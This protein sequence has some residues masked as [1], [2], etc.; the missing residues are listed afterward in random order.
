M[1]GLASGSTY[2]WQV[3]SICDST[4]I[5]SSAFSG[6]N[7]FTLGSCNASL[8]ISQTNVGCFGG[9]DGALDLSVS[10]GSGSFSYLWSDGSTTEDLDSLSAG[11]YSVTVTDNNTCQYTA[12][13]IITEPASAFSVSIIASGNPTICLGESVTLSMNS[14]SPANSIYQW[15]DLNG[16]I[17]GANSS[18]YT[19]SVSGTYSLTVTNPAGCI[20]VSNGIAITVLSTAVPSS[21]FTS[22]I[23]LDKAT[24]NWGSV[25]NAHKYH[26]RMRVQGTSSWSI[27]INNIPSSFTSKQ[28]VNL[29]SATA[30]EWSIRSACSSDTSSS[31]AWSSIQSFSTLAPCIVPVNTLTS[32][33]TLSGASLG[34]DAVAGSYGYSVRYKGVSQP[35]SAWTTVVVTSNAYVLSGLASGSTYHWQVKSICDST[36]INSSAFSGYNTFTLGSCN[37]SLNISQTNVGCFGGNDGALDL[38]VSGGSGSFSYLW[39][40]GSTTEDL[41]SLSAGTYSVTVTDNNTCQYTATYIIT[42]PAS[43]FSVSIIASGNPTICLGE[44]VTLSMNSWSPANSIY[45]WSDLNGAISGAN[46]ST[47]TTSVSGTYS[48]TVT[49]PAGCIAVSNGIAITVLSTAVPS[50]LFTSNIQ[51]DKATMNWGSVVNAHKYHI[52]MRVQGTSSWSIFINNIPSSFTSKQKVNLQSATA[53]EWSIRSACSSDTSSSS[54][55]SSIQSFS[56]LA[57]CIVPVNTLTSSITLSGASLGWDAVAGSYGYSVRYKGVS[58]PWSAWTTVVVTSNAYVLSGLASG[59]TYHWQVK[60]ICDSTGINSS[61]FSGYNTFTLGSCN[62]SLN[63]SQTNVGCFGGNDGALDLSVSGGSGSFSYLWSDGSTTEDLDSLSAG[64]YSVTVTDNNTCQYTATYIITEP[65]SAFSV[66]IIASGNP[67]ICLG[68][69]VTL[70]MN[71]WSPANSIYQ[72]SDLNGAISGANSS[73]YTTSVSGTYSLTVTNPAGCIAVSNGIAITVLSTAVPSS[74]FTSN[75]QLDKATMN[76]G[77]VVNA[78]KYHIRMRVQGTSSWSIFIN[79]IPSSFTSKQKVNLQSATAYEWS[80]RSACSSDTSSSSAWSSIQSFSTLAPCIVPVNTLTSSITLSGASLGWDAVAGSY[81]YSVRYKGVSQP[82]SAWTTVVVTSNAYVL[83]GLASG[84]TYHWQVKSICDSTGINSSAFSG[85]NTFTLG[86]CNASLNISQTNVG[87]FGGNDGA[88]DLSVSG[89]SGSF[90]YLWSDGSTTEDLDS[91]SAGTYSVTV[92]DNN[93]CQY[94]ATYIIT[95]PASAF[96]VSIIASGNPTICLGESV[97]L[98]MNSWSPANSIYQWSDLNGAIS[99][100]NSSTYTTSVSGTYSL[101]VTNP[102]GCIAVSNGIAI[103]VLSTA[104]PSSLF[105]SNIQLDKATMNWGSVVNAHKYHIRMRVQGTSSWSIFINNIPSSFTS[106]QKVNLQSAT[107]Y[108]WSIRS[109]CSSDTSSSSAWSSIQ[110]FATLTTCTAPLNM[111]TTAIGLTDATL[112]WDVSPGALGYIVRYKLVNQGWGT[113]TYDTI[114]TNLLVLSSLLPGTAYHW[115]VKSACDSNGS[116]NSGFSSFDVFN[117][118]NG[119][120]PPTNMIVDSITTS[121]AALSWDPNPVAFSYRLMYLVVGAPWN[122]RIDTTITPGLNDLTLS[123]LISNENYRFRIRT[124]CDSLGSYNSAWTGWDT[125]TTLSSIRVTAGDIELG[126][127]LNIY[128]NPTRGLFNISFMAEKVDDFEIIIVDAFGKLGYQEDKQAFIGEYTKQIDLS[129]FPRGIYMLQIRTGNSFVSK[130]IVLQ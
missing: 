27:F 58:Q 82:W 73:T 12:T 4:G 64:T 110:S 83:S 121:S 120:V 129:E 48:L 104:V 55:W 60:S 127:N 8:N 75:I 88:L 123:G 41:D 36:G 96:S 40:D 26:I 70:S 39:S 94:T 10:G 91:L 92:T 79:N 5:N 76:W 118:V 117:T 35:W 33:I 108:E 20:A 116:N 46:S 68:E 19:T 47:Y 23:Q 44:S 107:A 25:V 31:S 50:S 13:Y 11:T 67:T 56:T 87:C 128:P 90:S 111:T 106:K 24:M 30:Y 1:S 78:H 15:S 126:E 66:S 130:R 42:E 124:I 84:S 17:S 53:Y 3:K 102:A 62:A 54:A 59:S 63:I 112:G 74:L 80:I 115:Q 22:N 114:N 43:A 28:K 100:A 122:T 77:S 38:S 57:P 97:T 86:S 65:A 105:T 85:Y 7:T 21:L 9:N 52:R 49:N 61:A 98:S 37:A 109:A 32:S 29:Q 18:T 51:L 14:W 69:S 103:T 101:T 119:C 16:A 125:L 99:G 93:T 81:G 71:S 2:H 34:W 113:F 45:Q 95:E 89:G 6:Y 72:W